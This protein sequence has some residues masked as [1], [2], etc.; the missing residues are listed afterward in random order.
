MYLIVGYNVLTNEREVYA[1]TND[2]NRAFD[3]AHELDCAYN[4]GRDEEGT[5]KKDYPV[6]ITIEDEQG[7]DMWQECSRIRC[8]NT[9]LF[10]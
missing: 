4:I 6:Y 7:Q 1:D 2:A 10:E 3:L 8:P 9:G 5:D